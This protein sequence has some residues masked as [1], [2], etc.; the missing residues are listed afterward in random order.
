M[1]GSQVGQNSG[2]LTCLGWA[3]RADTRWDADRIESSAGSESEHKTTECQGS[4]IEPSGGLQGG[5][6]RPGFKF[7]L[8]HPL[9]MW[10]WCEVSHLAPVK[11]GAGGY[12]NGLQFAGLV[13]Q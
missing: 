4:C 13:P 6:K 2:V 1:W 7:S 12:V 5:N 8:C 9:P 10:P 11:G 3:L